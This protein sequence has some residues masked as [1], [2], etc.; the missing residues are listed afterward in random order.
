MPGGLTHFRFQHPVFAAP[1]ARF[2]LD[3]TS[4]APG[5]YVDVGELKGV[6]AIET[7]QRAFGIVPQST[8]G[9]LLELAVQGL[10]YVPDIRPGDSIPTELLTGEASWSV[11]GRHRQ[12][13]QQR[14][15]VQLVSWIS[16]KEIVLTDAAEIGMFLAQL[17][18]RDKLRLAFS[19]AAEAMGFAPDD[20]ESVI[21][22]LE[23][24]VRG[25]SRKLAA[26]AKS[27]GNDRLGRQELDRVQQLTTTALRSLEAILA[28][29]DAQSGEIVAALRSI[30]RQVGYIRQ[31]RDTLHTAL[32]EWDDY[33]PHFQDW[34]SARNPR[35]DRAVNAL[36]RFLAPR[37]T[38]GQSLLKQARS[39]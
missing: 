10:R 20:H 17:E 8:D 13:A 25:V 6:I 19:Q 2:A 9:Q 24:L 22:Q 18:T 26:I 30:E 33:F 34:P 29:A 23:L 4:R 1:G 31:A 11:T 27:Y 21:A 39:A 12:I 14:L 28:E 35:S 32:I 5:F 16:G 7:L 36:Y 15:Q 3:K 37:L 38:S